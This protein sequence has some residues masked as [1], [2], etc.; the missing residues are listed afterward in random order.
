MTHKQIVQ[1][2][3]NWLTGTKRYT[4]AIAEL[5]TIES[6]TPDV[7]GF[8]SIGGV[9]ILLECKVSRSD[10]LHDKK[11]PHRNYGVGMGNE[12]Y[13]YTPT[14]LL[15]VDEL[16]EGWGLLEND[17]RCTTIVKKAEWREADKSAEVAFLTS[18]IRRLQLSTCV[19]VVADESV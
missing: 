8:R 6:E 14:G 2:A 4:I 19:Y 5:T 11:K 3:K 18:I 10:F 12:R 16:P 1:K 13:F 7:I 15:N 9:S 17:G